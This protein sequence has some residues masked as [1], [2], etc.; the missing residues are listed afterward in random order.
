PD[1]PSHDQLRR[2]FQAYAQHFQLYPHIEFETTVVH[3]Q[4]ISENKWEV[5]VEKNGRQRT[6]SFSHLVVCNGH[7]WHPRMPQYPGNFSG[8]LIHSHQFKRA[9]PFEGK[10][11]L[12]IG[13]GNSACDVAVETSR[14]SAYTELSWRRGYRILPKFSMGQPTDVMGE[15]MAFLPLWLRNRLSDLLIHLTTGSNH[16][17]G[18]PQPEGGFG[19]Y[20]PTVNDELLYKIRHGKVKP[21]PDIRGFDGHQ[22]HFRDGTRQTFDVIIAC[23]GFIISHPFFDTD[24]VDY[25]SGP[26]LLY[27]K[28]FHP[29][30]RNLYFV[31]LFQP[32]GCI[33]PLS[34]LQSKI[35]A[36]ELTGKWQRPN[37]IAV[38]AQKEQE[39]P[40]LQQVKTARHT[41]TVDAHRFRK[42]LLRFLPK[43]YASK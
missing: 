12:V 24:F 7:H 14:V 33:W 6:E 20:H 10:R 22:V 2:Y 5:T 4:W 30:Y 27:R 23:T 3:C 36:R 40:H 21:R 11:V 37:N 39:R 15:R 32:L 9:A 38:L 25:S 41:I 28:M 8:D 1:Y 35:I 31:G 29:K 19:S 13:G 43:S 26:V 18:L 17:Y 42:E 16:L 34:E